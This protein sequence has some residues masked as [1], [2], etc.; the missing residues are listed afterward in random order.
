MDALLARLDARGLDHATHWALAVT[1]AEL[2]APGHPS[3]FGEATVAGCCAV[4]STARLGAGTA[5]LHRRLLTE[6]VHELGHVAGLE[7]CAATTCVMY[8]SLDIADTD[9]KGSH[10]CKRCREALSHALPHASL[11]PARACD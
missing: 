5:T 9:R 8:P 1:G 4:V 2:C 7:H 3:V 6:A 10:F 11:D